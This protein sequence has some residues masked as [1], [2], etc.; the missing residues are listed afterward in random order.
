MTD[1][2]EITV[3]EYID[4]KIRLAIMLNPR[5]VDLLKVFLRSGVSSTTSC[6]R[7][8]PQIMTAVL[9][10]SNRVNFLKHETNVKD[11]SK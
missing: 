8:M 5:L 4:D 7:K 2:I 3:D 1:N 9:N 11:K 10:K 6:F